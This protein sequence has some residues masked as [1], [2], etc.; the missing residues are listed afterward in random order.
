MYVKKTT[1][2]K[3]GLISVL[4]LMCQKTVV[5]VFL[6]NLLLGFAYDLTLIT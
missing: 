1:T 3:R 2:T 5:V 4:Q 6:I